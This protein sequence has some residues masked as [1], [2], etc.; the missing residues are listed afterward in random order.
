MPPNIGKTPLPELLNVAGLLSRITGSSALKAGLPP[1]TAV[2]VGERKAQEVRITIVNYDREGCRTHTAARPEE[3]A[4]LRGKPG[5]TWINVDGLHQVEL[6]E[7]VG[8][9]FN[10]HPLT[11]EDICNTTQRPKLDLFDDH[12]FLVVRTQRYQPATRTLEP[13][14]ISLVL[15]PNFLLTFQ[16]Q[17]GE[18]FAGVRQRLAGGKGRIRTMGPDYLAYALLDAVVDNYFTVLEQLGEEIENVEDEVIANPEQTTIH[19]IHLLK[20]EL[21]LL[22]KSVWPLREILGSLMRQDE[23]ELIGEATNIYLRDLYDHTIQVIDTLETY[24]D[25]VAGLLDIYLSSL[26]NR[27]NE[28]MKVLTIFAAIFI[29]LTFIAG[30]Y[31]MNFNPESSP[32]NMPELHWYWGYPLALGLMAAMVVAMLIYFKRKRWL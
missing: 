9:C 4:A 13:D 6:I 21:I 30:V 23:Q 31:G 27:M 12:L 7:K 5:I 14:Q 8:V 3:C 18:L 16:E 15:G 17:S 25:V 19:R 22:R 10:L 29:P 26:S 32:W 20:R 11:I 1:G 28:I 24:R 2:H